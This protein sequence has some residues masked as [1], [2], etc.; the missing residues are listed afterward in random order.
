MGI[1][2]FSSSSL[3][4][5][6]KRTQL[7]L[8]EDQWAIVYGGVSVNS[9]GYKYDTFTSS[10]TLV[11]SKAGKLEV[12]LVGGGGGAN[13]N[14]AGGGGAGQVLSKTIIIPEGTWSVTVGAG[15]SS[16]VNSLGGHSFIGSSSTENLA[17]AYGGTTGWGGYTGAV[18][19]GG[20]C[21]SGGS[22]YEAGGQPLLNN[23]FFGKGGGNGLYVQGAGGGGGYGVAG[24][25]GLTGIGGAG[26]NGTSSYSEWG[27]ATTTGHNVSGTVWYAGGGGGGRYREDGGAGPFGA[28]GLG[29]GGSNSS[30]LA[31]TGGAGSGAGRTG[32][33]GLVIVRVPI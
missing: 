19:F 28:G 21:G 2:N 11:V 18:S 7:S 15:G 22:I 27:L 23:T 32:G 4:E 29:G 9:G 24:S 30:G 14:A 13:D 1:S 31:N 17:V 33:S 12:L 10:G 3:K 25:P 5:S 20:A 16:A 8:L 26:G 6:A